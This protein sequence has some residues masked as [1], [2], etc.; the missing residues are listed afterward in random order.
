MCFFIYVSDLNLFLTFFLICVSS[1]LFSS[2]KSNIHFQ[3]SIT[4]QSVSPLTSNLQKRP[5]NICSNPS[6]MRLCGFE[7]TILVYSRAM[8]QNH[9]PSTLRLRFCWKSVFSAAPPASPDLL[10]CSS[11]R[12]CHLSFIPSRVFSLPPVKSWLLKL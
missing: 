3:I 4:L 10:L 8:V 2:S 12:K 7:I 1:S 9:C 5:N 6:P 11:S